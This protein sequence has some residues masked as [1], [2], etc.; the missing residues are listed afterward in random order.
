MTVNKL[1]DLE[2]AFNQLEEGFSEVKNNLDRN[3]VIKKI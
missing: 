2:K 3:G 1:E